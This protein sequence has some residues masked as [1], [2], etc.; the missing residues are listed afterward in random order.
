MS[1]HDHTMHQGSGSAS[2][3]RDRQSARLRY[4]HL[5]FGVGLAL[6]SLLVCGVA[7]AASGVSATESPTGGKVIGGAGSITQHGAETIVKQQSKL[8]ALDWQTF[9]VGKDA[10]VLFDQP[11]F[12]AVA[13]N[14]ILDQNPSQIFGKISSNGQIF[15][16]NTHG[17]IFGS[18]AQLNVGGLVASTLDLTPD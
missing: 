14:R 6:G 4:R 2:D 15:L 3:H 17:I 18:T 16:I 5:A 8:L 11:S 10:S 12:N 7:S 13:L 1:L 9:N